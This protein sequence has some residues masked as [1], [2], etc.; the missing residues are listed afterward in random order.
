MSLQAEER[1]M[2]ELMA[3]HRPER[4][5]VWLIVEGFMNRGFEILDLAPSTGLLSLRRT[6]SYDSVVRT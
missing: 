2:F 3:G 4:E 1:E 5:S 6:R